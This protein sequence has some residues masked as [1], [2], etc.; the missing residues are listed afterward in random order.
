MGLI[1]AH[2]ACQDCSELAEIILQQLKQLHMLP[3]R[4]DVFGAPR[5][6]EPLN[7]AISADTHMMSVVQS[8]GMDI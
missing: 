4:T 6:F 1:V 2:L 5:T 8:Y 7:F 3:T